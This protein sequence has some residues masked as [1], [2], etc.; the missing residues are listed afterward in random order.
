MDSQ[1]QIRRR[2]P[3]RVYKKPIG[4]LYL[5]EY[6]V[7]LS[8]ELG[9]GGM[10]IESSREL[11]LGDLI[12]VTFHVPGILNT[13]CRAEIRYQAPDVEGIY[14]IEFKNLDFDVKRL[15]R[16]YVA[17]RSM[18]EDPLRDPQYTRSS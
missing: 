14:G 1:N 7:G 3:R 9:E 12:L 2:V 6:Q 8:H 13:T 5:G 4:L 11:S 16:K 10:L 15:I 17:Q 18:S